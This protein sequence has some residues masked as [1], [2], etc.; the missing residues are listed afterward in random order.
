MGIMIAIIMISSIGLGFILMR[1]LYYSNLE[2]Q[3]MRDKQLYL[4]LLRM[5][6]TE[7]KEVIEDIILQRITDINNGISPEEKVN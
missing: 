6:R 4:E 7:S 3:R 1:G 2:L 5:L